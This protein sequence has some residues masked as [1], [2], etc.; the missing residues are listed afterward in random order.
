MLTM[1]TTT[2][3]DSSI[4][5]KTNITAYSSANQI[6]DVVLDADGAHV[7]FA[8]IPGY[9]YIVE[10]S[11]DSINWT[12]AG[13]TVAAADGLI[14]FLDQNPPAGPIYYRTRTP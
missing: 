11:T 1:A 4:A 9:H 2:P 12:V 10:R 8:G 13:S 5:S 3:T 6:G 14:E 7:R